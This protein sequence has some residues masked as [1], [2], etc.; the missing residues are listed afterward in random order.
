MKRKFFPVV[1]TCLLI[2]FVEALAGAAAGGAPGTRASCETRCAGAS[3]R[4]RI[5]GLPRIPD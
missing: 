1:A 3:D 2:M 4:G 5:D